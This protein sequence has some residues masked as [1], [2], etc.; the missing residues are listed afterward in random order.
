MLPPKWQVFIRS[1]V[2]LK[3]EHINILKDLFL[4]FFQKT[5]K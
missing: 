4:L 1:L 3:R 2:C 5:V